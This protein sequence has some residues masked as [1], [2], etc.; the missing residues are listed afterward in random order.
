MH[1]LLSLNKPPSVWTLSLCCIGLTDE[2]IEVPLLLEVI[3]QPCTALDLATRKFK[4]NFQ[5]QHRSPVAHTMLRL[6]SH[7]VF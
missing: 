3:L 1:K 5:Q 4:S 2:A 6:Q 7:F